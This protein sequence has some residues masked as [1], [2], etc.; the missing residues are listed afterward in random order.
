M[1]RACFKDE[2]EE[3]LGL[4]SQR[5]PSFSSLKISEPL[6]VFSQHF[7]LVSCDGEQI[8]MP[9]YDLMSWS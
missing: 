3:A 1:P 6:S 8:S 7:T 4:F 5:H 9:I 2:F